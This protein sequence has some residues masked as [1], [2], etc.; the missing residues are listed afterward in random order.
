[1]SLHS[2]VRAS[3]R[4]A[5][6]VS[7]ALLTD[8]VRAEEDSGVLVTASRVS[9]SQDESFWSSDVLTRADIEA[10]QVMSVQE[11]LSPLVGID[12]HNAGGFGKATSLFLRG[13]ESDQILLLIDGV[14]VG[15]ATLGIPPFELLPV[16]EIERIEV[17][18]GPRSTLYGSDAI[19]GVVQIFTRSGVRQGI[20]ADGAV[21]FG[22][23][24]LYRGSAHLRAGFERAWFNIGGELLDTD[25]INSCAG[26]TSP[27]AGCFTD[28]P[29]RDGFRTRA[30]TVA[31]G[32]QLSEGWNAE[33][34]TL[35][36]DGH[37]EYDGSFVNETDFTEHVSSL[38]VNGALSDTWK[39]RAI[40]GRNDDKQ[41]NFLNGVSQSRFD[42]QRDSVSIQIDG[43]L[44]SSLR[45]IAGADYQDDS[46]ESTDTFIE[47][48]RST[49]G[50]FAELHGTVGRFSALGGI[51]HEDND[52]FGDHVTR[53][54]GAAWRAGPRLRFTYTWGEAFRAPTFNEL[55]FP[56]FGNPNLKPEESVS[57]EIGI[58]GQWNNLRWSTHIY[59]TD[60]DELI[61]F[62][63]ALFIP[64]NIAEA[65]IRG[66]EIEGD[67]RR[68]AWRVIGRFTALDAEDVSSG[69]TNGNELPRRARRSASL[70]VRHAAQW[71]TLGTV[72]RWQGRRYD[73]LANTRELGGYLTIDLSAELSLGS[74][75][76]LQA[77]VTNALDRDYETASL[78]YHEGRQYTLTARY[79]TGGK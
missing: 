38:Q 60:V 62:D 13:A 43:T 11:L 22:S 18:R 53:T 19:G 52:Q 15:S 10:R 76:T 9:Q 4:V 72:A 2:P 44:S 64:A 33:L 42:S 34:H 56:F 29:D 67:W 40:I 12:V 6:A 39:L 35:I 46:V 8:H 59:Q 49:T 23:N 7:L 50:A 70:E 14:R 37:T 26:S 16:E 17:V 20:S 79:R 1:M 66:A 71:G 77:L 45:L 36:A 61:S 63:S 32:V 57:N 54:F 78:F 73:D 58:E 47:T 68:D 28:E 65:R 24:D 27:P 3:A 51:R 55:Y 74:N 48:E 75:W 25:G 5:F 31:A 30:G 21:G 69:P 41:H